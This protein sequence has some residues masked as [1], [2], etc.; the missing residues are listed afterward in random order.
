MFFVALYPVLW[1]IYMAKKM[2]SLDAAPFLISVKII[3]FLLN[4]EFSIFVLLPDLKG[5]IFVLCWFI[6]YPL[7]ECA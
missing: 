4:H 1:V 3:L 2:V 5:N 6:V 7:V